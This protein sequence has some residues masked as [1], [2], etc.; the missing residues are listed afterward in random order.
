M[1]SSSLLIPPLPISSLPRLR[2]RAQRQRRLLA[3]EC[4]HVGSQSGDPGVDHLHGMKEVEPI[5]DDQGDE[6]AHLGLGVHQV[7]FRRH[8][9]GLLDRELNLV[10]FLVELDQYGALLHPVVVINQDPA[11]L[12]GDSGSHER[13]VA[14]DVSVVGGNRIERRFDDGNKPVAPER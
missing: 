8:H 1:S 11:H 3:V 10:R 2:L 14:V 7:C 6:A 5:G 9:G 4:R 13:H 12:A